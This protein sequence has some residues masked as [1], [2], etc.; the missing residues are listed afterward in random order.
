MESLVDFALQERYK[1][2]KDLGDR[3]GELATLIEWEPFRKIVGDS[4]KTGYRLSY[5]LP[6]SFE[7]RCNDKKIR[8][9][10]VLLSPILNHYCP[11]SELS[12]VYRNTPIFISGLH[13]ISL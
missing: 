13:S 3:L 10:T 9:N 7:I 2:V 5:A 4:E 6:N 1:Q 8:V 12:R 11:L